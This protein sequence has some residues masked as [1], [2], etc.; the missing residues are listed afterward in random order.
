MSGSR[1]IVAALGWAGVIVAV[2]LWQWLTAPVEW[3]PVD[4]V[5]RQTGLKLVSCLW[6]PLKRIR[7]D[8]TR[9]PPP[10]GESFVC[11]VS[12]GR[13][14]V[15]SAAVGGGVRRWVLL[16]PPDGSRVISCR[17]FLRIGFSIRLL[18]LRQRGGWG[19]VGPTL[20]IPVLD[21]LGSVV[22]AA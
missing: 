21:I 17:Q 1:R 14:A 7:P 10:V 9:N 12:R 16:R 22:L 8:T 11:P 5:I 3:G 20:R 19:G 18:L 13:G 6:V 2:I 4:T 15:R